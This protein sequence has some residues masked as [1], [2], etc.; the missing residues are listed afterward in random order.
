[1]TGIKRF[2]LLAT[3]LAA[4]AGCS[5]TQSEIIEET[6]DVVRYASRCDF[7]AQR[8]N[9]AEAPSINNAIKRVAPLYPIE[10]ARERIEGWAELE[11]DIS[12]DGAP[13]NI[14]VIASDSTKL[15]NKAASKSLS[16][17]RYE[18]GPQK[19][20]KMTLEFALAK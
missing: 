17:W 19:C 16:Q 14:N 1:M 2:T 10:A 6:S 12:E 9:Q 11:Y 8:D 4:T 13:I 18:N 20:R 7:D 3:V 5:S 15:F